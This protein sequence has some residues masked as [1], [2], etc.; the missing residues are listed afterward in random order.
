M[1]DSRVYIEQLISGSFV[2]YEIL[3]NL[4]N[5]SYSGSNCIEINLFIDLNSAI[6]QLYSVDT[7]TYKYRNRYEIA[8]TVLNMCGHYR[9][10]FRQIGVN[11]NIYIIYGLNCPPINDNLVQGYNSAF[12][13]AFIKKKDITELIDENLKILNIITQYIPYTYFFNCGTNEVSAMIYHLVS[14]FR[15]S[16]VENIVI[17]KDVLALQL[18]PEFDVRVLRPA[19]SRD[20]EGNT[21]DMSFIVDNINLW[22]KFCTRYR[23]INIPKNI[24]GSNFISN[25]LAMTRVPERKLYSRF[26]ISKVFNILNAGLENRFINN[27]TIYTQSS[28]N[29]VLEALDI[30]CNKDELDLRYRAIST[31]YQVSYVLFGE[32]PDLKRPRIIDLEDPIA[33]KNIVAKYFNDIPIDLDRL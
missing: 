1:H 11:T 26:S 24:I 20:G 22:E 29:T 7:W 18:I 14:Y 30:G 16:N 33:L 23:N 32:R 17:T 19:K 10:F 12:K 28:I 25:V 31:Q 15:R 8:A 6:K 9:E 13:N 27:N 4:I 21:I 3:S 2:R 5:T